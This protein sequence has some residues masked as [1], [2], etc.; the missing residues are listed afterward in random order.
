M[1][2]SAAGNAI[3]WPD[4]LCSWAQVTAGLLVILHCVFLQAAWSCSRFVLPD[5]LQSDQADITP[6]GLGQSAPAQ[7]SEGHTAHPIVSELYTLPAAHRASDGCPSIFDWGSCPGPAASAA[8]GAHLESCLCLDGIVSC[9]RN[10]HL[11]AE[12]PHPTALMLSRT[13]MPCRAVLGGSCP[14][15]A[16]AASGGSPG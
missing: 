13:H 3:M 9:K 7:P 15:S 5:G 2:C 8:A 12:R 11:E 16:A 10:T 6:G 4:M 1:T 14:G